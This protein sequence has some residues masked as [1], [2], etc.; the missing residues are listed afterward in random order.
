MVPG[1]LVAHRFTI[2]ARAGAGGMG[3]VY[4]ARD[5][6]SGEQVA[7]KVLHA[8]QETERFVRE[9]LLLSG[10][11]DP[12]IVRYL[13]HG[14]TDA[15]DL[16]LAMEWLEGEDLKTR[17]KRA[18]LTDAESLS[19]AMR[20]ARGLAVVH[21]RGILHRDLKPAN[22]FLPE[23]DPGRAK[24]IDFGIARLG[25][26]SAGT[27]LAGIMLGTPGYMAPEQAR[28]SKQIDARVDVFSLGCI[29]YR[30][31]S[32]RPPFLGDNVVAVLAKLVFEEPPRLREIR[33]E[34]PERVEALVA[35]MMSKPAAARPVDGAAVVAELARIALPEAG[36]AS[37]RPTGPAAAITSAEQRMASIVLVAPSG[38]RD[39]VTRAIEL[40]PAALRGVAL[41]FGAELAFLADGSLVAALGGTEEATDRAAHAARCA[42]AI[43]AAFPGREMVL[44][45][46]RRARLPVGELIDRAAAMLPRRSTPGRAGSIRLDDVTAGLLGADFELGGDGSSLLLMRE[47]APLA[48]APRT[49]LGRATPC[50][51]RDRELGALEAIFTV[52]KAEPV[53][54]AAIVT[55]PAGSGKSRLCHEFLRQIAGEPAAIWAARGD[56]LSS[57]S[58]LRMLGSALRRGL[59]LLDEDDPD[60]GFRKLRAR[61]TRHA[62]ERE[63]YRIALFAGELCGA[64]APAGISVELDAARSDPAL[65][66]DQMRRAW[67]D[68]LAAETEDHPVLIVLE[69]LQWGDVPTVSYVGAAL[70]RFQ[71]RPLMVLAAARPEVHTLFPD[72]WASHGAQEIRIGALPDRAAERLVREALG[73]AAIPA[74]T[75]AVV[76]RAGGNAFYLEELIRAVAEGRG[77]A[78]PDTVLAMAQARLD[79]LGPEAKRVLRAASVFGLR[80]REEGIAAL[81]GDAEESRPGPILADL[82]DREILV[83]RPDRGLAGG[84]EY[85]FRQTLVRDAAHAMLTDDDRCLGHRLAAAWLERMGEVDTLAEHWEQGREPARAVTWHL[86]AAERAL[87]G[88][89]LAGVLAR[90]ERGVQ[91]MA[92]GET[93]GALRLLQAIAQRWLGHSAEAAPLLVEAIP[94]LPR[95][96]P[97][98]LNAVLELAQASAKLGDRDRVAKL[99]EEVVEAEPAAPPGARTRALAGVASQLVFSGQADAAERP[100]ATTEAL[101]AHMTAEDPVATA[102]I[103]RARAMKGLVSGDVGSFL[104]EVQIAAEH[105]TKAGD[106]RIAISSRSNCGY[107]RAL[108]GDYAAAAS[109]LRSVLADAERLGLDEVVATARQNLGLALL[110]TGEAAE[111]RA[112]LSASLKFCVARGN[113]R[114]EGGCR[115]YLA[116]IL[117]LGGDLQ[118]SEREARA[119]VEIPLLTGP[120]RAIALME[121]SLTLLAAGRAA[122]ALGAATEALGIASLPAGVEE[123]ESA[124]HLA[125]IEAL[126]AVGRQREA[127][128]ALQQAKERLLARAARI[129][130]AAHRKSFLS[131][132]P[133]NERLLR[134][135]G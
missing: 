89:D 82:V 101:L 42:L 115:A 110:H 6:H 87:R 31:L 130:D 75:A 70:R 104:V 4:R 51:G 67:E 36:R 56:S 105:S 109:V 88:D 7:L 21:A 124:I 2:E 23:G 69:D 71:D 45:T 52:C 26:D 62:P 3:T 72:L 47:R 78:F 43:H 119:A 59:G 97:R 53:A 90:A 13:T 118:G 126:A 99:A 98:W 18:P 92:S 113:R 49:L 58:A 86:A 125:Y 11:E 112:L 129:R 135:S 121:L 25:M 123:G 127:A 28:G 19:L 9:A 60:V 79:R 39:D 5:R 74:V 14:R 30:C 55:G 38:D 106:V 8:D 95:G 94:L 1:Q 32:G 114:L 46:G 61:V 33:P 68:L 132:V 128:A 102:A 27:T 24:I 66:R 122:E 63:A 133:E 120:V 15:G 57:G 34:I 100:L 41:S 29:L 85:G 16:F 96:G 10:L 108:L 22:L 103:A 37:V 77:D 54:A 107:A 73:A 50:V 83:P 134:L 48:A 40:A 93:L 12:S 76:E 91:C 131:R 116:R 44:A 80:F 117:R 17:L 81:L 35:R 84:R 20:V 64:P 111:A 65:M